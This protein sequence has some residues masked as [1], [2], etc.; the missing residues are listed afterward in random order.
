MLHKAAHRNDIISLKILLEKDH[1]L[2]Y[3]TDKGG[4]IPLHIAAQ[5]GNID[6]LKELLKWDIKGISINSMTIEGNTPLHLAAEMLFYSCCDALVN[7]GN[8]KKDIKNIN[9]LMA[10]D[11]V[12]IEEDSFQL[13]NLLIIPLKE[14]TSNEPL[15]L[16]YDSRVRRLFRKGGGKIDDND[17]N[18]LIGKYFLCIQI[19]TLLVNA[20]IDVEE[21]KKKVKT[22]LP[23]IPFDDIL[24]IPFI[25]S[26]MSLL[27]QDLLKSG[28][29]RFYEKSSLMIHLK[30]IGIDI[31]E[32]PEIIFDIN[33]LDHHSH[34]NDD[35]DD[36]SDNFSDFSDDFE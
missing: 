22:I 19:E 21:F 2:L 31:S 13:R 20:D 12:P 15:L 7:D 1:S 25:K 14:I 10:I 4:M 29:L 9:G 8:A 16:L 24:G 26:K 34:G 18:S 30:D 17:V 28:D 3:H 33:R 35:D 32:I 27:W 36:I 6:A 23:M 5:R 11:F